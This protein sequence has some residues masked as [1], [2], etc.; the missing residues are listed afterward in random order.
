VKSVRARKLQISRLKKHVVGLFF[1]ALLSHPVMAGLPNVFEFVPESA[2]NCSL[3]NPP[4]RAGITPFAHDITLAF[5]RNA[6][7]PKDFTGC[8]VLW[9]RWGDEGWKRITT[10]YFQKGK[11]IKYVAGLD[12][13]VTLACTFPAAKQ[14][15]P[16][17]S[18]NSGRV[19][20]KLE[21]GDS[22]D[23]RLGVRTWPRIC[24]QDQNLDLCKKEPE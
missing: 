22:Q 19:G 10:L 24:Q 20:C 3:A 8:Q 7:F 13:D 16:A 5:P 2:A 6:D 17:I 12:L 1:L 21:L 4:E 23:T 11:L 9:V 15:Y 18:E 14:I